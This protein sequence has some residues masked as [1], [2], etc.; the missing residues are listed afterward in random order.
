VTSGS[1]LPGG[2]KLNNLT[3]GGVVSTLNTNTNYK[4]PGTATPMGRTMG[5]VSFTNLHN[6]MSTNY[7]SLYSSGNH[8]KMPPLNVK[9]IKNIT[10]NQT[11]EVLP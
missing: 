6:P 1:R 11:L 2:P 5:S 8:N 4:P 9:T 10:N 3:G 7:T